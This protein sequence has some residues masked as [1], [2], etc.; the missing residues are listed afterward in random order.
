MLKAYCL[1]HRKDV[2]G[3]GSGSLAV[4]ATAGRILLTDYD[5]I[6]QNLRRI[7]SNAER[8]VI[9][10]LGAD[11]ADFPQFLEEI[12][13]ISANAKV[14]YIDHHFMSDVAKRKLEETG[15]QLVHNVKECASILTYQTFRDVLPDG[16]KL[17]ALCGA[18][19]DYMDDS[20]VAKKMMERAE[21][22]FVLL[23]ATMLSFALG[24]HSDEEG[25]PEMLVGELAKMKRPDE[26]KGV[27]ESA[28]A[29][30]GKEAVLEEEVKADG[31]KKGNLAYIVTRRYSTS[32][33]SKV[34][35]GAFDVKV[36]VA[37][38]E[39]QPGWYEVSLRSTSDS[40]VHLGRSIGK[41]AAGLGG[42]GGGHR[43]AAGCR[44]PKSRMEEMIA[45]LTKKA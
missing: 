24:N 21:R 23:E 22:H 38:K 29:Q 16:A 28:L 11:S 2:D 20:P 40:R 9:S 25:Y 35:L 41:I 8:V 45:A 7:P 17:I 39:K 43:R 36:G 27:P 19:T 12:R 32:I 26:I 44:I 31:V 15:I 5:D 6:V 4:A 34:L 3:L 33:A 30:L 10:D 42:S 14:T 1:S 37:L 18:V 13:R